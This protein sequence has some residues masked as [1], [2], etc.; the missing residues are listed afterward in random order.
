M[1]ACCF[2]CRSLPA[3][4]LALWRADAGAPGCPRCCRLLAQGAPPSSIHEPRCEQHIASGAPALDDVLSQLSALS[5]P[6]ASAA[7]AA[8]PAR[9]PA[10]QPLTCTRPGCARRACPGCLTRCCAGHCHDALCKGGH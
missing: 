3:L 9:R 5:M 4:V 10:I 8:G 7:A 6:S 2:A 1:S